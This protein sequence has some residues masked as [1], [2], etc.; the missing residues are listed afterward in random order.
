MKLGYFRTMSLSGIILSGKISV[1]QNP[2]NCLNLSKAIDSLNCRLG[3]QIGKILFTVIWN[4]G[5][6]FFFNHSSN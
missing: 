3:I 1:I 6:A 4:T 5:D 2:N